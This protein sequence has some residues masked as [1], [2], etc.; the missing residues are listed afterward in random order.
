MKFNAC[1]VVAW[2]GMG[3]SG[4]LGGKVWGVRFGGQGFGFGLYVPGFLG[5]GSGFWDEGL[6]G[7]R[8]EGLGIQI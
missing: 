4:R 5:Q 7:L 3:I 1:E 6:P 8:V 2:V